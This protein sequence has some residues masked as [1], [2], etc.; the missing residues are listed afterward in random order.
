MLTFKAGHS[1]AKQF[2]S[3]GASHQPPCCLS[4][5]PQGGA[6]VCLLSEQHRMHPAIAA[7]PSRRFLLRGA[8]ATRTP[9]TVPWHARRCYH[10]IGRSDNH[11][12]AVR[13][14][15]VAPRVCLLS[16]AAPHA[17][18]HRRVALGPLLRRAPARRAGR[19]RRGRRSAAFHAAACFPPLALFGGGTA[20]MSY[21]AVP[22]MLTFCRKY[23]ADAPEALMPVG[24]A[25]CKGFSSCS[26]KS[27]SVCVEGIMKRSRRRAGLLYHI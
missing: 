10:L 18:C 14:H 27:R 21:T 17:P 24:A 16:A 8:C 26:V 1:V 12:P 25:S 15:R 7:W 13:T 5:P 4:T 19:A 9:H 11:P 2:P 23:F 20:G 6:P 3:F 22:A